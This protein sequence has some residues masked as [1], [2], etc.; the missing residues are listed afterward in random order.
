MLL[1]PAVLA[2]SLLF[3]AAATLP[4]AAADTAPQIDL[5]YEK[6]TL[7]NGLRVIV[8]EDRK[9]PIVAVS[10]WYHVGSKDEPEGKTGFAHLFEH[11]MFNGSENYDDEFFKPLEDVGATGYNGTTSFDRTNYFQNVPTPALDLA[12]WLESDRMGHLLGAVTQEKLDQ[13]RG[14]VQNEKRQNYD[15]QPYGDLFRLL[16][17]GLMPSDHPYH[18]LPIGSMADLD[19][20]SLDDVKSWFTQY[21]GAANAV[22]VLAGD[23]DAAEAR[24]KMETYF[25]DIPAGPPLTKWQAWVPER[26][27]NT[28]QLVED[29]VP[30]QRVY[31][32]WVAPPRTDRRTKLLQLATDVLGDGKNSRIYKDLVYDRQI[33]TGAG[34]FLLEN[35]LT[36]VV[37]VI[38]DVKDGEDPAEVSARLDE[39]MAE[40][41][42]EGPSR[43]ELA[44]AVTK[45]NAAVVRGLEQVGGF[46]G[47]AVTLASGEIYAGDPDFIE[48]ELAWINN[49]ERDEVRDLAR[50]WLGDG[51]HQITYLP[52]DDFTVAD[53]GAD[54]SA[55][56]KVG[57]TPDLS[58]P[59][60]QQATLSNGLKVVL[61]E[62]H[63]V[64]VV[65]MRLQVDAGYAADQGAPL[66]RASFAMDL[67]D[68][69]T[70]RRSALDLAAQL[71]DLGAELSTA[72]GLDAVTVSLS[73]L[74]ANLKPSVE[75]MAEVVAEPAFSEAEIARKKPQRIAA[76][77]QEMAQPI[78]L[79]LRELPPLLYGED[80]AY[81]VPFTGSG[82]PQSVAALTRADLVA[83]HRTWVRPDNATLFVVGDTT[84]DEIEPILERA[85]RRWQAPDAPKPTK[86]LSQVALPEGPRI[87]VVD[88]PGSPQSLILAGHLAPAPDAERDV[89]ITAANQIVGGS[90]TARI[91]MNVR[92]DKGWAYGASSFLYSAQAQRPY[93]LYAPVQADKTGD[94]IA[95]ILKEYDAYLGDQPPTREELTRAV[96]NNTRS[97]PGQY[98]TAGAV[99]GSLAAN[100]L[101]GRPYDH[102]ERLPA[103]W[104][105]LTTQGVQET[106]RQV[107]QPERLTWLI[108]GDKDV[109]A[110]E[111]AEFDLGTAQVITPAGAEPAGGN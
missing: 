18:H 54:R 2:A 20:A 16:M 57:D 101:Y 89:A 29:E 26:T 3:T 74:K 67:M 59:E 38:V 96:N 37:G 27:V 72:A 53:S 50:R 45:I 8:H 4:K 98:E 77:G 91:N 6:F 90:F 70:T 52:Y 22:V 109:I 40:F 1:R 92:E 17:D 97:L 81:G 13:Q 14:V 87:F 60:V 41:R 94:S 43:A 56:P 100:E 55:L 102:A 78:G 107:I 5:E 58:F 47:K 7:D 9:A 25:G 83:F 42:A 95:E 15:N 75:L 12:L 76:I 36:S 64:P 86:T 34:S 28:Y 111:L 32:F 49:A 30:Q 68:E 61:A 80:H 106:A 105:A 24:A 46:G 35:E 71:E 85:F 88:R 48:T 44:R 110:A 69:G 103:L 21:Y 65:E 82:T 19:A 66:G 62:R 79:A 84:L 99:L 108:V 93:M 73:A 39:I 104:R 10:V 23:I 31:R 63:A 11:L 33:A 51:F